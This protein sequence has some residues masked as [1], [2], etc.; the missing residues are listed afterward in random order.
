MYPYLKKQKIYRVLNILSYNFR[1]I[2]IFLAEIRKTIISKS[3]DIQTKKN[4]YYNIDI[5]DIINSICD[6]SFT[7][8]HI[9]VIC[10]SGD[11]TKFYKQ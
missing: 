6:N 10:R 8:D 9:N 2:L 7:L 5:E 1:Q 4:M 3:N 11:A